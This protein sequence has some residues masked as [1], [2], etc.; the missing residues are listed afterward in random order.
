MGKGTE[1]PFK[2]SQMGF[3]DRRGGAGSRAVG[4][5]LCPIRFMK[6][7]MINLSVINVDI[8]GEMPAGAGSLGRGRRLINSVAE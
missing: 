8:I 7:I 4:D 2:G 6:Q 3:S 1:L 5:A